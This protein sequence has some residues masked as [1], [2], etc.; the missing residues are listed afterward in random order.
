LTPAFN[1]VARLVEFVE[2]V[3]LDVEGTVVVT[4]SEGRAT[5]ADPVDP[6][7]P[8]VV[9]FTFEFIFTVE[10]DEV[11]GVVE[12]DAM[13]TSRSSSRSSNEMT[14][15]F[16]SSSCASSFSFVLVPGPDVNELASGFEGGGAAS[17][18]RS[19]VEG[20]E[21]SSRSFFAG[22]GAREDAAVVVVFVFAC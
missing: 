13:N 4:G 11:A 16:L 12:V 9:S 14:S 20:V 19:E 22:G 6:I 7:R 15:R 2:L 1:L 21:G 8:F 10:A 18:E 5:E 3:V 17:R